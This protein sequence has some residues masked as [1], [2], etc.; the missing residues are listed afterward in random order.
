MQTTGFLSKA[1]FKDKIDDWKT[2]FDMI[3]KKKYTHKILP[4][5]FNYFSENLISSYIQENCLDFLNETNKTVTFT[6]ACKIFQYPNKILSV[7]ILLLS[8][9]NQMNVETEVEKM[10]QMTDLDNLDDEKEENE[11]EFDKDS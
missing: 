3:M 9:V 10:Y 6:I 11:D 1:E 4:L 5:F 2:N 8:S 7:R